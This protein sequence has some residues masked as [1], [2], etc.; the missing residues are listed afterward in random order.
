MY[1]F[2]YGGDLGEYFARYRRKLARREDMPR[3]SGI[4]AGDLKQLEAIL[5]P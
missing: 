1:S 5:N 4:A 3:H 2:Q